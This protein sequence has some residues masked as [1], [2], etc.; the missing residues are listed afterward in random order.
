MR[1]KHG[2]AILLIVLF[3]NFIP[4]QTAF[5]ATANLFIDPS[6]TTVLLGDTF[7]INVSVSDVADLKG[8]D[9]KLYYRS[10]LNATDMTEGSFLKSGG[11]TFFLIQEFDSPFNSTHNCVW[12]ACTLLGN[13]SGV[14]GSGTLVTVTF[15]VTRDGNSTL[16][17]SDTDLVNSYFVGISHT[18]TDGYVQYVYTHNMA[19]T[20]VSS[21]KTSLTLVDVNATVHNLGIVPESN[22]N[23][24]L[25]YD[26][27]SIETKTI[28]SLEP[29]KNTTLN[30]QWDITT[31]ASGNYSISAY[32]E[33]VP[34]E[35]YMDDNTY[36]DGMIEVVHYPPIAYFEYSPLNPIVGETVT[37]N[38]TGSTPDGGIITLYLWDFGDGNNGTGAIIT[39][40]Y[41]LRGNYTMSLTITDSEGLTTSESEEINVRDY[42]TA[43]FTYSPLLPLVN[44]TIIFNASQSEP[45]GGTI[46]SYY[47]NFGD[48]ESD[49][50]MI[51]NH[52]FSTQG[53]FNVTLTVTDSEGLSDFIWQ[54]VRVEVVHDV[55]VTSVTISP[56]MTY[57]GRTV[58]ITVMVNNFG[59]A[60]E[61]FNVKAYYNNS[62]IE[63]KNVTLGVGEN[64]TLIFSW[65]TEGT[66]P[67]HS[68]T[69]K[70]E[71]SPVP[72]ERETTNNV[73]IAGEVKML[74]I[75]DLNNDGKVDM[76]DI[77]IVAKAFGRYT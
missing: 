35:T 24:S 22:I 52:V 29:S 25:Y 34:G 31:V 11:S 10:T 41:V 55:A 65:R 19:V 43:N 67:W 66:I 75:G 57:V 36:V 54:L 44:E 76:K 62:T 38:A 56:N 60:T 6:K 73:Y 48:G 45:N 51:T 71:A 17:L 68:Y 3:L 18:T 14:Y 12:A 50:G 59:E 70:A 77:A 58:N 16:H 39:H 15:N 28:S 4:L 53:T 5:S 64:A 72:Y 8:W 20:S 61:T 23:I 74:F 1:R 33:P 37:F 32:I 42:P 47:W 7:S 30:F 27:N 49:S 46:V 63:T 9:I 2:F 21:K 26:S 69:I 40:A 13:G